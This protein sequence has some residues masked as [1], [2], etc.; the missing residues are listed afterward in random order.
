MKQK[1]AFAMI[2]GFITTAL[3]SFTLITV[4]LGFNDQFLGAWLRSWAIS[5]VLAVAAV[6]LLAQR[7]Q[8][9]VSSVFSRSK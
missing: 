1:L 6:L 9:F 4:N 5:Y 2:M 3:I 8:L 7:V